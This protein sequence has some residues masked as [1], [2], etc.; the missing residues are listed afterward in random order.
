MPTSQRTYRIAALLALLFCLGRSARCQDLLIKGKVLD[1]AN[2]ATLPSAVITAQGGEQHAI[3]DS[4]GAFEMWLKPNT[5]FI[6][7]NL[8]GY[9]NSVYQV[10]SIIL[11][12][13]LRITVKLKSKSITLPA[14][15]FSQELCVPVV[16]N[17]AYYVLDFDIIDQQHLLVLTYEMHVKGGALLLTDA[18]G[19]KLSEARFSEEPVEL[20]YDCLS[21][22]HVVT[23]DG[24]YQVHVSDSVVDLLPKTDIERFNRYLRPCVAK[25]D[26]GF[27]FIRRYMAERSLSVGQPRKVG[28]AL[29][30]WMERPGKEPKFVRYIA[31][32]KMQELDAG[33]SSFEQQK[34]AAEM[35][36]GGASGHGP[37]A[38]RAFAVMTLLKDA[39]APLYAVNDSILL[40]NFPESK[41]EVYS[42]G[43]T[44][45]RDTP[46]N[47]ERSKYWK[48]QLLYDRWSERFYTVFDKDGKVSVCHL[49][50]VSGETGSPIAV[51]EPFARKLRVAN[52]FLY[53]I[54]SDNTWDGTK[55]LY[56]QLLEEK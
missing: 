21:N 41:M 45:L 38:D 13:P 42:G 36:R 3:T 53:F 6:S 24:T 8:L 10:P 50:C 25:T 16:K 7:I 35:Y 26:S 56:R 27:F 29:S 14:V 17:K 11:N 46:L 31:D 32:S 2:Q 52:G 30:Y 39:Y 44:Q 22:T 28:L 18:D 51:K 4:A 37:E 5:Q 12:N 9:E 19:K 43:G 20:F 47:F 55:Y 33:E 48:R 1:A 49:D 40:F 15:T 23:K 34:L 54:K